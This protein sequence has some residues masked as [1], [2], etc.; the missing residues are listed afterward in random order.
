MLGDLDFNEILRERVEAFRQR[1]SYSDVF[2]IVSD[3]AETTEL[4]DAYKRF[5]V[6]IVTMRYMC[7]ILRMDF[8]ETY[9]RI[10]GQ[11]WK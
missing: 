1:I 6:E 11:I 2:E 3:L 9:E 7:I 8:D 4:P 10:E 5:Y